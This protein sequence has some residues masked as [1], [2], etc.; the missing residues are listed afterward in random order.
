MSKFFITNKTDIFL[1][2]KESVES[3]EYKTAFTY[4]RGGISVLTTKKLTIDNQNG[5]EVKD[6]FVV[7]T[8]T[9]AWKEGDP[10]NPD[11]LL[12]IH[13]VFNADV[14]YIRQNSI[15][16]YSASIY[17]NDVLYIFGEIAGF[18]NI[19]YYNEGNDWL[20][21][22]SLYDIMSILRGHLT[23]NKLALIEATVQDGILLDDTYF[24]E[25]HRLSGFNYLKI[26][27]NSFE[28]IEEDHFYP[29]AL[30]TIDEKVKKYS[31]LSS[32]YAKKIY[33]AYGT[34]AISMTGGLD[35][36][37]VLSSFLSA[38]VKPELYYGTGDSFITNT[39]NADKEIDKIFSEN[40]RLIFHDESWATPD[41]MDKYWDRY[42]K[43]YGFY[44]D[45]YAGSDAFL[46]S[47]KKNP[48]KIF[49]FGYCGELLRNLPWI[50]ARNKETFSL[51]EYINELYVT[52][53]VMQEIINPEDYL[54][55]IK[56]KYLKICNHYNLNIENIANEDIFYLSLER[57]KSADAAILNH[58][59]YIK[60]CSYMLGE[61]DHLRAGRVTCREAENSG[62][63]LRCL[64]EL[65][66]EVLDVPVFSHCTT[67]EFHRESMSLESQIKPLSKKKKIKNMI[68][69]LLPGLVGIYLKVRGERRYWRF[70]CDENL[71]KYA[72]SLYDKY[73]TYGILH[74]NKF[75]DARRLINYVMKVYALRNLNA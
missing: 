54:A 57:R 11:T 59:N 35:A 75:D 30:G 13:N 41:P 33:S 28:V 12:K 62:F 52:D 25:V 74:R 32:S 24:N 69:K 5:L 38:D 64:F 2:V 49:N 70:E 1:N 66:P 29:I 67:R 45:T 18:Y 16:N 37:M 68:K 60:F 27:S 40:F 56:S 63:M 43:L 50:E 22:N 48:C 17:K 39:Y 61:Y 34:P 44:Y 26:T 4:N 42:L 9:L 21:S 55:Y 71:Y 6:G 10:I 3:S 23:I 73:D 15:G 72:L 58:V 19:Y 46:E 8:G 7:V 53:T 20:I 65:K 47:L 14:N 36:R 31:H 51:D